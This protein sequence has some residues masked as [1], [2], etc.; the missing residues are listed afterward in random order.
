MSS[1]KIKKIFN[2]YSILALIL[3]LGIF[4]RIY[5]I[6]E[7]S[8]WLDEASTLY[9]S[10]KG[11]G[12]ILGNIY[13]QARLIPE[14]FEQGGEMPLYFLL[15]HYWVKMFGTSEAALRLLPSFFGA[16]SIYI[17]FLVGKELF[18]NKTGLLAS[19]ILAINHQNIYYSQ[20]ARMYSL[21]ALLALLS[22]YFFIMS[23]KRNRWPLWLGYAASSALLIYTHYFGFLALL[24]HAAYFL[25]FW[26]RHKKLLRPLI[27]SGAV[28]F[29]L[30]IPWISVLMR[31]TGTA[32][33]FGPAFGPPIIL[34]AVFL[35]I[36]FNAWISPD[37]QTRIALKNHDFG[38]ITGAGMLMILSILLL[39]LLFALMFIVGIAKKAKNYNIKN[40]CSP[41]HVFLML[42]FLL[43][44]F[45]LFIVSY[46]SGYTSFF[47]PTRYLLFVTPAYY[48]IIADGIAKIK[49][50]QALIVILI[51]MLSSVPL[52]NYYNNYDKGQ[53]RES[54]MHI[55]SNM[56]YDEQVLVHK[57]NIV[58]PFGYYFKGGH[59]IPLRNIEDIKKPVK[60]RK[61]FWLVV[62]MEKFSGSYEQIKKYLDENYKIM[63][64]KEFVD[65]DVY[66]Y[67]VADEQLGN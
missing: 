15:S 53:Y 9:A 11:P 12:Y 36:S 65:V 39:A 54:A 7:E 40:I 10:L 5:G 59:S 26:N 2:A 3:A 16:A 28:I 38:Q 6:G 21:M 20:E 25:L 4:L 34:D 41:R 43:P 1:K 57:Y 49:K 67:S 17:I 23:L 66:R 27:V 45:V 35:L 37:F 60:N 48:L 52:Y 18:N 13:T 32:P 61:S 24:S 56:A 63:S 47:G 8:L 62:S 58:I 50:R 33:S 46:L 29:V 31:Q 64:H 22:S 44:V 51:A 42:W 19:F 55:S 30:Y 14:Y